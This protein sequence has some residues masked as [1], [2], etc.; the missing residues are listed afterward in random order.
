[1]IKK[2][3]KID[4]PVLKPFGKLKKEAIELSFLL[5]I[6]FSTTIFAEEITQNTDLKETVASEEIINPPLKENS[7][8]GFFNRYWIPTADKDAEG[9]YRKLIEIKGENLFLIQDFFI[10]TNT[11]QSDPVLVSNIY[12]LKKS[13]FLKT[14][15]GPYVTW[16]QNGRKQSE[17]F[18]KTAG[19]L[20]GLAQTWYN[21]G[22]LKSKGMYEAGEKSGKWNEWSENGQL[23]LQV[24]YDN[25]LLN[26]AYASW[27]ENGQ[28]QSV[29]IYMDGRLS[30]FW[31]VWNSKGE[32]ISEGE[33]VAGKRISMWTYY[34][35][36]RKWAEGNYV[37]NA[38]DGLWTYWDAEGNK[39]KTIMYQKGVQVGEEGF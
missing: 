38:Q 32:K 9:Y 20:E 37:N 3:D 5:L 23:K 28:Q 16:Y 4:I 7:I 12:D 33:Y 25:G 22:T 34:S 29:G 8:V 18:Y 17:S 21:N 11:K 1:M 27:Y 6:M 36:G 24:N 10:D 2:I 15:Q 14:I 39:V 35:A 31:I 26:G 30:G 19:L 13:G